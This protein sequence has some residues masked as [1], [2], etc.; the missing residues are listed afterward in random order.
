MS[1]AAARTELSFSTLI[2]RCMGLVP[3]SA[4][5]TIPLWG[6]GGLPFNV[7][8]LLRTLNERYGPDIRGIIEW[9][10]AVATVNTYLDQVEQY[11][12]RGAGNIMLPQ[13]GSKQFYPNLSIAGLTVADAWKV[14]PAY[15]LK[16]IALDPGSVRDGFFAGPSCRFERTAHAVLNPSRDPAFADFSQIRWLEHHAQTEGVDNL[17]LWLGANNA[18]G[19]IVRMKL[20]RS[21][22]AEKPPLEMEPWERDEF[23]LWSV[24]H[25]AA[26][27]EMLFE[28][29]D[30]ALERQD[31]P[32]NVFVGTIPPV[33]IAP[34]A[35]GVG[36]VEKKA[37]P[38]GVLAKASY[39]ERYTYFLFDEKYAKKSANH[40]DRTEIFT[41]DS[42]IAEY[43][44]VIKKIVNRYNARPGSFRATYVVVDIADQL[45]RLAFK[46]ND[47]KPS[48]PLPNDLKKIA[49]ITERPV[50]TIYY[51][52][53]REGKM[54]SG[55]VF[56]LDGVHPTAIGQGLIAVEFMAAMQKAGVAFPHSL[57]WH[58][59][60]A[61]DSLYSNPIS[62]IPELYDNTQ[63]ASLLLDI[64]R[65][66]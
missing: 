40:L 2:A 15:C 39:F 37:D 59:I 48:Y 20:R 9:G 6:A 46:R 32:C 47:G 42:T 66:P 28:K 7:E 61:S 34:L 65:L 8:S 35:K 19:T 60:V 64:L 31:R 1:L 5:Y 63:L 14:T 25:F 26:E 44:K 53:N 33:T 50:N 3:G 11:Y 52:V 36:T 29:V 10:R 12:E 45:L 57:D 41:I 27:Y 56:S 58:A 38:F 21:E 54:D 13:A 55:G 49:K 24:E 16:R 43:N 62:L 18:L 17:I 4:K 22:T 30:A 51:N 23:N